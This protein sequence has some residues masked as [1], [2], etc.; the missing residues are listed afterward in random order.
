MTLL[1]FIDEIFDPIF[2]TQIIRHNREFPLRFIEDNASAKEIAEEIYLDVLVRLAGNVADDVP[3]T[4]D[5][6]VSSEPADT[7]DCIGKNDGCY[8]VAHCSQY[9][10]K[11]LNGIGTLK[12]R[13]FSSHR[14]CAN[15]YLN[16]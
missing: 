3:A 9:Y 11:C 7:G 10:M 5:C 15:Y 2:V 12:V 13:T 14:F 16:L 4:T 8:P 1:Q 6:C